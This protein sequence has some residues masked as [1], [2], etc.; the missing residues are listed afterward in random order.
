MCRRFDPGPD[1]FLFFSRVS[2]RSSLAE[3]SPK[4]L[5]GRVFYRAMLGLSYCGS[6]GPPGGGGGRINAGGDFSSMAM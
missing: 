6:F 3:F 5:T 2:I 1:H 4:S